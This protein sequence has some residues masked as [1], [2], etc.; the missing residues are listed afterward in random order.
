MS[1]RKKTPDVLS[2]LLGGAQAGPPPA[3]ELGLAPAAPAAPAPARRPATRRSA[4][5]ASAPATPAAPAPTPAAPAWEYQEV[6]FR[7]FRGWRPRLVDG[8]E[9][10]NWK[11]APVIVDYLRAMGQAGWEL[12]SL[13]PEQHFQ[14]T[15]YFKRPVYR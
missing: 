14:K 7:E 5:V 9:Q 6:V 15:A 2:E 3:E 4:G 1:S 10:R 8:V 12:V 11:Q 13:S